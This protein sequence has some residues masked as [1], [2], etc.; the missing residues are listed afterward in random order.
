MFIRPRKFP[1]SKKEEG[2]RG[3]HDLLT[4]E[5]RGEASF[6]SRVS[7][8]MEVGAIPGGEI[9]ASAISNLRWPKI[10]LDPRVEEER[11]VCKASKTSRLVDHKERRS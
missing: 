2:E 4:Q 10:A 5:R 9:T 1:S 11:G 7:C 3:K 8:T 6:R